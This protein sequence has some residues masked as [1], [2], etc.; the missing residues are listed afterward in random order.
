MKT[1]NIV[2]DSKFFADDNGVVIVWTPIL[3][4]VSEPINGVLRFRNSQDNT[5][6]GLF[7]VISNEYDYIGELK[8]IDDDGSEVVI[9]IN[10]NR[11][12]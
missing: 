2:S 10:G 7:R 3:D 12:K 1:M 4:K 6:I 5:P 11:V 8:L 9:E